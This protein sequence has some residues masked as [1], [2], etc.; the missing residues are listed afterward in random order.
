[1]AA[2]IVAA[3]ADAADGGPI[4][5]VDVYDSED[6]CKARGTDNMQMRFAS[7]LAHASIC[8][9][10]HVP[11]GPS[12]FI[13]IAQ[14]RIARRAPTDSSATKGRNRAVVIAGIRRTFP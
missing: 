5:T 2:N 8:P 9:P 10:G 14:S 12:R 1:L 7:G 6:T 4:L 13:H 11:V 3:S